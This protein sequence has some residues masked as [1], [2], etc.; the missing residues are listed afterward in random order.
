MVSSKIDPSDRA[1]LTWQQLGKGKATPE[2]RVLS[3]FNTAS[4]ND[5]HSLTSSGD[6]RTITSVHA[7]A[8]HSQVNVRE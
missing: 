2:N 1:V 6:I 3:R 8:Q 4:A 7:I 5:G